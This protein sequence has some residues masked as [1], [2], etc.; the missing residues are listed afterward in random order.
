[1]TY[2]FRFKTFINTLHLKTKINVFVFTLLVLFGLSVVITGVFMMNQVIEQLHTQLLRAEAQSL[3]TQI[4]TAYNYGFSHGNLPQARQKLLHKLANYRYG[5]TGTIFVLN[6]AG[7]VILHPELNTGSDYSG[8]EAQRMLRQQEGVLFY[9]QNNMRYLAYFFTVQE[10]QWLVALSVEAD[11]IYTARNHYIL[12]V[13]T[14]SIFLVILLFYISYKLTERMTTRVKTTLNYLK[15]IEGGSYKLCIPVEQKDELG[16]LQE[17][18][19]AMT[20]QISI[21]NEVLHLAKIQAENSN[22]TKTHFIANMSHELR[23]PLN[24]IIGYSEMLEED[25][26]DEIQRNDLQ[27]INRSAHYLLNLINSILDISKLESGKMTLYEETFSLTDLLNEVTDMVTPLIAKNNNKLHLH[28]EKNADKLHTDMTK[29][30]Q[31]LFNLLSNAAKFTHNGDI[32]LTVRRVNKAWTQ[33]IYFEIKDTGIGISDKQQKDLFKAFRQADNSTTRN[34]GGTGL[35]LA[36]S[37]QFAK[38]M[39]GDIL[40]SSV[41]NE[42]STFSLKLLEK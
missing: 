20:S 39:G 27:K 34:Y 33:W 42:G 40:I 30:R 1:M 9:T 26:E 21:S 17:G 4:H 15:E 35:G 11:E 14:V 18:I 10:W 28:Y 16:L 6:F 38:M 25:V 41:I 31:I 24:A 23:T 37:K 8:K 13:A 22:K 32:I 19:N 29:L 36:I 12:L 7:E 2:L 3:Q 5:D